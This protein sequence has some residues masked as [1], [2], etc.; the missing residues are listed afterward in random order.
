MEIL[1]PYATLMSLLVADMLFEKRTSIPT[2]DMM[3]EVL[4]HLKAVS[5]DEMIAIGVPTRRKITGTCFM[6]KYGTWVEMY[7]K[8]PGDLLQHKG[9]VL[10]DGSILICGGF[11]VSNTSRR[12]FIWNRYMPFDEVGSMCIPRFCHCVVGLAD[13]RA[14][15][16]GGISHVE[17]QQ[18]GGFRFDVTQTI[19]FY[20]PADRTWTMANFKMPANTV[21]GHLMILLQS[22]DVL[23]ISSN[24]GMPDL[25]Y[26]YIFDPTTYTFRPVSSL[27]VMRRYAAAVLL[28]SGRVLLTGGSVWAGSVEVIK[29][30]TCEVYDPDADKWE[31][32]PTMNHPRDEHFCVIVSNC[33]LVSG[34]QG[35]PLYERL[36]SGASEWIDVS[37]MLGL[38]DHSG[39]NSVF[40]PILGNPTVNGTLHDVFD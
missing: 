24:D 3:K 11:S 21:R 29:L 25:Y 14:M 26:C 31:F 27:N 5:T 38:G 23:L 35:M 34:C 2:R 33:V 6:Y 28:P 7:E 8:F 16:S 12:S 13:G 40:L 22:G 37:M 19:E 39:A 20:S 30:A 15:A 9:A 17:H 32:G 18:D 36:I 4:V 1:K 10:T